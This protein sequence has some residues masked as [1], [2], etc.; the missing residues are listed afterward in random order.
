MII[1][2]KKNIP[3]LC[4]YRRWGVSVKQANSN[5]LSQRDTSITRSIENFLIK[6]CLPSL[7]RFIYSQQV[8]R[9]LITTLEVFAVK[10]TYLV[11]C[12]TVN[13]SLVV[14]NK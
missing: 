6:R 13:T 1:G 7:D 4:Q 5:Y 10:R 9:F 8:S 2:K 12:H 11:I 3:P 14:G